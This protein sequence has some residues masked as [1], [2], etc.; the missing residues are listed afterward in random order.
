MEINITL[1][2]FSLKVSKNI[3]STMRHL[4]FSRPEVFYKTG[5]LKYLLKLTGKH[6]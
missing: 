6:L 5:V 3:K 2:A 1:Y 4:K